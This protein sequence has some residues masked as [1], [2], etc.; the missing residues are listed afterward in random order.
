LLRGG[1]DWSRIILL[2]DVRRNPV[3]RKGAVWSQPIVGLEVSTPDQGRKAYFSGQIEDE[4]GKFNIWGL[5]AGGVI[6]PEE[7]A[8][9]ETLMAG[10]RLPASLATAIAWRIAESQAGQHHDASLPGPRTLSDLLAIDD[11]T[12]EAVAI[13]SP[14]LSIL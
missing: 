3:T 6:Q 5:A 7:L 10:L 2:N 13:L 14:Y 9:L 12:A 1:L 4:Q 11:M 8:I